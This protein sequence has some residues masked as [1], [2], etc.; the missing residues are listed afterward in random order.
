VILPMMTMSHLMAS[1]S[2]TSAC[3]QPLTVP[4]ISTR[5]QSWSWKCCHPA[6]RMHAVIAR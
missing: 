6:V 3:F 4:A 2:A 1:G 5:P